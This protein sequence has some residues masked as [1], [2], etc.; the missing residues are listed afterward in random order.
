MQLSK[1]RDWLH[2]YRLGDGAK[3]GTASLHALSR[4]D[5]HRWYHVEGLSKTQLQER[6]RKEAGV[7]VDAA[8][9]VRWLKAPAQALI[10]LDVNIDMHSHACGEY[11]LEQLQSG[12]HAAVVAKQLL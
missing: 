7:F 10:T 1:H 9:W 11:V 6:C 5:L 8:H 4:Q 3:D 12:V 2:R